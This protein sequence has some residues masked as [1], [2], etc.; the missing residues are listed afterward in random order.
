MVFFC[1]AA[2][3]CKT[4]DGQLLFPTQKKTKKHLALIVFCFTLF[5]QVALCC[6]LLVEKRPAWVIVLLCSNPAVQSPFEWPRAIFPR[7]SLAIATNLAL[8]SKKL[9][10][11]GRMLVAGCSATAT[12]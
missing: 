8:E 3:G 5:L 2:K 10:K 9:S 1:H 6:S 4:N 11:N 7:F 12:R